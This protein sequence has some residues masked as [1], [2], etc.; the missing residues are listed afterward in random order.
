M[1]LATSQLFTSQDFPLERGGTLPALEVAYE[2]WGTLNAARDNAVLVCH[3][4]T[5]NQHA[6]G[7]ENGWFSGVIGPGRAVDTDRFFVVAANMLGSALGSTGPASI[8]PVRGRAYGLDFPDIT[9]GDMVNAQ[10]RLLDH[11]GIGQL[12][13]VVGNS[14]GGYLTFHWGTEHPER[15]RA[16]VPV[17]SAIK[18]RGDLSSVDALIARFTSACPGWDGGQYYGNEEAS[19][20]FA[21]MLKLRMET[22]TNYGYKTGI[23]ELAE[24]WARDFD[25]NSLIVLRRAA[26]QFDATPKAS[27]IKAPML[28]VLSRTDNLFPPAIAPATMELLESVG[29][30]ARYYEIDSENGHRAPSIDG[31]LWADELKIFMDRIS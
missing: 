1:L 14:F 17:V 22:L 2:T 20:V 6:A 18:G 30:D 16:L 12:A 24:P 25:A 28:Y 3:G 26:V 9:V 31:H 10:I 23:R 4:Y 19:G 11:F 5:N 27:E 8:C 29:V 13:A 7:D 15:M 21:E